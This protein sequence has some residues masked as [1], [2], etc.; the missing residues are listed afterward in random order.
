MKFC[1]IVS[2]FLCF[3]PNVAIY[4]EIVFLILHRCQSICLKHETKL[5]LFLL[6]AEHNFSYMYIL[7]RFIT[8]FVDNGVGEMGRAYTAIKIGLTIFGF[9]V[10]VTC[11]AFN[12]IASVPAAV[13]NEN[14]TYNAARGNDFDTQNE[15]GHFMA[16]VPTL[17]GLWKVALHL[18][19]K[20]Y[21]WMWRVWTN[22]IRSIN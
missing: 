2:A 22:T 9:L 20:T 19:S 1:E 7:S 12:F 14:T 4:R 21:F 6:L 17:T 3:D 18:Q 13:A 15:P 10:F 5:H 8:S 11:G 16:K